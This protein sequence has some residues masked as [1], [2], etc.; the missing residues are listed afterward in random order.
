MF[1]SSEDIDS[2]LFVFT[3]DFSDAGISSQLLHS[4]NLSWNTFL[5]NL[6][7]SKLTRLVLLFKI[8]F[9]RR[10]CCL[11]R[12]GPKNVH[13]WRTCSL[14]FNAIYQ[15]SFFSMFLFAD[16]AAHVL[17]WLMQMPC[18]S[19]Q[20]RWCFLWC[21]IFACFQNVI[22]KFLLVICPLYYF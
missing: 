21:K 18:R 2:L 8:C 13:V 16:D 5:L 3:F 14:Y 6:L 22:K 4:P 11:V 17:I 1:S 19:P 10:Q 7:Y 20:D 9:S 15:F 12:T